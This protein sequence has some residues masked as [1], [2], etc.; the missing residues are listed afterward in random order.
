[1]RVVL[2]LRETA[3]FIQCKTDF[4]GN[5]KLSDKAAG[6]FV[7]SLHHNPECYKRWVSSFLSNALSSF[8]VIRENS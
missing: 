5:A 7:L 8:L 3:V 6:L 2:N 1:M 4:V